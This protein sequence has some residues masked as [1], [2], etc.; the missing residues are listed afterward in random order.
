M[1]KTFKCKCCGE[2][3]PID[4]KVHIE[5]YGDICEGCNEES[6]MFY[7]CE[8]CG[9]DFYEDDIVYLEA[10]DQYLCM[11]CIK[12]LGLEKAYKEQMED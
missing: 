12:R 7:T 10:T 6:T 9:K 3:Y 1:E 4:E 5:K 8:N 11:D 2:N